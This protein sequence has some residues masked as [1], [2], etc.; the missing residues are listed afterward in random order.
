MQISHIIKQIDG[1]V[2]E[3]RELLN[4]IVPSTV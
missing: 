1:I 4:L 2:T 3:C